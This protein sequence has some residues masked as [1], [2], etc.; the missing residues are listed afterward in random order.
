M[1]PQLPRSVAVFFFFWRGFLADWTGIKEPALSWQ[2]E[3]AS[4]MALLTV[5]MNTIPCGNCLPQ[6]DVPKVKT[7]KGFTLAGLII[8]TSVIKG[9]ILW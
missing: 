1:P 6:P 7:Q 2:S 8:M 3:F 5:F 4:F 9:I